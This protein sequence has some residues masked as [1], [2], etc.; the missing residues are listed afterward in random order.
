MVAYFLPY[1]PNL[2][3]ESLGLLKVLVENLD[4]LFFTL[5]PTAI[6]SRVLIDGSPTIVDKTKTYVP[7]RRV[8]PGLP[9][10]FIKSH[11]QTV[12]R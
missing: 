9:Q 5:L 11:R 2:F 4:K 3:D 1:Y 12:S 8:S 7:V 10:G 6:L